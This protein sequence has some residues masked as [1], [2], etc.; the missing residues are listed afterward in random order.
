MTF[1][2][3]NEFGSI[4]YFDNDE[5]MVKQKPFGLIFEQN[6][7]LSFLKEYV[8]SSS[9]ILDVGAHCG[10]H[11][12]LYKRINPDVE[13]YA[14]EPQAAMYSLLVNNVKSNNLLKVHCYNNAV[15]DCIG[16]MQMNNY[17][18]DG[19]NAFER[20]FYDD[21]NLFNLAGLSIGSGGETVKMV[22]IDSL[23]IECDFIK[24]DV[25]G[26]EINVI[27]GAIETIKNCKPVICYENNHK[28]SAH[29]DAI[30]G[31]LQDVGYSIRYADIDNWIATP[32]LTEVV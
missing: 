28:G 23:K 22:T 27:Q 5:E 21:E 20:V 17:S 30:S 29:F 14:F 19:I 32:I 16:D 9:V 11:T 15:G 7:V 1:V 18:E 10:S 25:E 3:E 6:F 24:I 2:I 31:I 13:V 12:L 8:V 4:E 26:Y